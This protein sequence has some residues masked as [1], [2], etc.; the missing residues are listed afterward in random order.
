MTVKV[1]LR[2]KTI[3]SKEFREEVATHHD[4]STEEILGYKKSMVIEAVPGAGKTELLCRLVVRD[5]EA[6][7]KPS[8]MLISSFTRNTIRTIEERLG[9]NVD[10]LPTLHAQRKRALGLTFTGNFDDMLVKYQQNEEKKFGHVYL[11]EMEDFDYS[12]LEVALSLLKKKGKLLVFLDPYQVIFGFCGA[13]ANPID[14]LIKTY[15][16]KHF[17]MN[18]S[19]RCSE[20]V[21]KG[22]EVIF[23]RDMHSKGNKGVIKWGE[24]K[25]FSNLLIL[26]RHRKT[27]RNVYNYLKSQG[28]RANMSLMEEDEKLW[29]ENV[30]TYI[31][32]IHR[33]RSEESDR[34]WLIDWQANDA[35]GEERNVYYVGMSRAKDEL[36]ISSFGDISPF[37]G[38]LFEKEVI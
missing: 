14:T 26:V 13:V 20:A 37:T 12:K 22:L 23:P 19:Y 5:L 9:D 34:V 6:G 32:T 4:K 25:D 36:Y 21:V 10:N 16:C 29:D 31:K 38:E 24:P 28:V 3:A 33:A 27:V 2:R 30:T 18:H 11:D 17:Y 8:D 1:D 35:F 7:V 15:K